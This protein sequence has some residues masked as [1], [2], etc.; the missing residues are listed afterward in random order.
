M[1]KNSEDPKDSLFHRFKNWHH[2]TFSKIYFLSSA[3]KKEKR[4]RKAKPNTATKIAGCPSGGSKKT[5]ELRGSTKT[6]FYQIS[7]RFL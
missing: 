6:Y 3:N 2:T 4:K 5:F 1:N 7:C